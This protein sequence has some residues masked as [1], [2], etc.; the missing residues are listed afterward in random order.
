MYAPGEVLGDNLRA[1]PVRPGGVG[2][3]VDNDNNALMLAVKAYSLRRSS[4]RDA[5]ITMKK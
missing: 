5:V 4:T 2:V 3:A 1:R